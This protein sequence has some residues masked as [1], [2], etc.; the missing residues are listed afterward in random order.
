MSLHKNF[1]RIGPAVWSAK[2]DIYIYIYEYV[3]YYIDLDLDE[4]GRMIICI[5]YADYK[6]SKSWGM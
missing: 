4:N 5:M 1:S 3:L 2:C 6:K